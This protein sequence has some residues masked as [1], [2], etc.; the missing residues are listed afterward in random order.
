[1]KK[2][3]LLSV[4]IF[5]LVLV[6]TATGIFYQTPGSPIEYTTVRGEQV[7]FQGSGLYRYDPASIDLLALLTI[8][9][10]H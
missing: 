8:M 7:I 6:A 9:C 1:M 3:I 5:L 4:L 10:Y 2:H